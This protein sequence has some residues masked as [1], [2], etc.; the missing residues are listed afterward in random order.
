VARRTTI[1]AATTIAAVTK[2][3]W[4]PAIAET[5]LIAAVT[6]KVMIQMRRL[7]ETLSMVAGFLAEVIF[8]VLM[9]SF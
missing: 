6:E 1:P 7:L 5:M 2:I 9:H 3:D 4:F 8:W